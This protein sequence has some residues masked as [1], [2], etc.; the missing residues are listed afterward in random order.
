[1]KMSRT[2]KI[3]KRVIKKRMAKKVKKKPIV[4]SLHLL[5]R[6]EVV[7]LTLLY[8]V[9]LSLQLTNLVDLHTRSLS[10]SKLYLTMYNKMAM[11]GTR[12]SQ[13]YALLSK[14]KR[15]KQRISMNLSGSTEIN[16][17]KCTGISKDKIKRWRLFRTQCN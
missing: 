11:A 16:R 7:N 12:I 1:M 9:P 2:L 17:L 15:M 14:S 3:L 13:L 8:S 6:A 10:R 4:P 5:E